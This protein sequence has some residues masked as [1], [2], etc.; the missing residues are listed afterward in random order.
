MARIFATAGLFAYVAFAASLLANG[1]EC[2]P[3]RISQSQKQ[4]VELVHVD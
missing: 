2:N 3:F 4:D 1:G